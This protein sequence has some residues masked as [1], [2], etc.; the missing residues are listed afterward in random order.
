MLAYPD[1]TWWST[2]H[3]VQISSVE[4]TADLVEG[5]NMRPVTY[6]AMEQIIVTDANLQKQ[7]LSEYDRNS[8]NKS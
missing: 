1:A 6:Q 5:T 4:M 3:H 7:L 2:R 8:K